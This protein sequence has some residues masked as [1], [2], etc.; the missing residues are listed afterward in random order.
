[1]IR[2]YH[3]AGI[4]VVSGVIYNPC[5][6]NWVVLSKYRFQLL[7]PDGARWALQ[8]GTGVS[9]ETA[10]VSIKCHQY[11]ID[12]LTHWVRVPDRWFPLL[13]WWAFMMWRQP[14]AI[15]GERWMLTDPPRLSFMEKGWDIGTGL[16]HQR[17]RL[18]KT[19]QRN[20]HVLDSLTTRRARCY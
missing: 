12:L 16:S 2:A 20:C 13:I 19:M 18:R 8:N 9:N 10:E 6:L 3:E 5:L 1:M 17:I 15:R 4:S 11:M 7:L 14:D